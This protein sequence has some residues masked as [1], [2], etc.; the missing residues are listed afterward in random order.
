MMKDT[1]IV[2]IHVI[3]Y[4]I[5]LTEVTRL[6]VVSKSFKLSVKTFSAK[7]Y[8]DDL[9]CGS[10]QFKCHH[11]K[12][13]PIRFYCDGYPDCDDESDEKFCYEHPVFQH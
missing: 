12:C 5:V 3:M 2:F 8:E 9:F 1:S 6:I 13:I 10:M 7:P 11:G 4:L